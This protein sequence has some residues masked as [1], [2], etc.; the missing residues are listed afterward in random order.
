MFSLR[1]VAIF[2]AGAEVFHTLSHLFLWWAN[3][4]PIATPIVTLTPGL[5]GLAILVNAAIAAGL[6]WFVYKKS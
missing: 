5:N 4:L 6:I 1:D 3:L 2:F